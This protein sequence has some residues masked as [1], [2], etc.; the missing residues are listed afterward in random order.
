MKA[1]EW[2]EDGLGSQKDLDVNAICATSQSCDLGQVPWLSLSALR[3][4]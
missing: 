4:K 1:G 3:G 2:E